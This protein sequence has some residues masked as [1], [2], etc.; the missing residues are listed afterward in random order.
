MISPTLTIIKNNEIF[1]RMLKL[2][3][4]SIKINRFYDFSAKVYK[5]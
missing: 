5:S 1:L 3:T 2:Q 4:I